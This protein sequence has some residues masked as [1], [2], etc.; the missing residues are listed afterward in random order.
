[1]IAAEAA[2]WHAEFPRER[3]ELVEA[4]VAHEMRPHASSP[5]PTRTVHEDRHTAEPTARQPHPEKYWYAPRMMPRIST[6][7]TI[8]L[9][10]A[11]ACVPA[12]P[13]AAKDDP[14]VRIFFV[15]PDAG[16]DAEVAREF[17]FGADVAAKFA[18]PGQAG[19]ALALEPVALP[20]A[21][22][23]TKAALKSWRKEAALVVAWLPHGRTAE[24]EQMAAKAKV[25]LLVVS[26]E[27]TT[28]SLDAKRAVFWAG[29]SPLQDET[30]QALDYALQPLGSSQPAILHDG[31]PRGVA[32]AKAAEFW[33]HVSQTLKPAI[34]VG[35]DW[36][37][38]QAAAL[39]ADGFDSVIYFGAPARAEQ[40]LQ[41]MKKA[42][43]K[44]P[45]LL[46]TGLVS[47]A[48]PTFFKGEAKGA[49]AME[50]SWFEDLGRIG[51][52]DRY[53]LVDAA[54]AA[55]R[56]VLP[57]MMRG[58]R[59]LLW[60]KAALA[61]AG[62]GSAKKFVPAL[63]ALTRKGAAEKTVFQPYGHAS[64]TRFSLWHSEPMEKLPACHERPV[65]R[66]PLAG[67][68][69]VGFFRTQNYG[70][71]PD[72]FHVWVRFTEEEKRT[73]E[74]DLFAIGLNTK[75]YE[76]DL[77]ARLLDD[78]LGR[79]ISKMNRLFLRN[80]DGR[81]IPGVS[82]NISFSPNPPPDGVRGGK[83]WDVLI[84]GDDPVAGGRA[85]GSTAK[86]FST[87]IRRTMYV[88]H[89]LDPPM[90]A[91]D[92][93]H[94][95]GGYE[96]DTS[97]DEN[98]RNGLVRSLVGGFTQAMGLTGAHELGHLAGCGHDTEWGRSIMNVASGAGLDFEW[99]DWIPAHSK[100][101][102]KR[103]GR[104]PAR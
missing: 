88:Q 78:L 87:F 6:V 35:D 60:V 100:V 54:K 37:G 51:K 10:T 81:A 45:V 98:I 76:E 82:Y 72:S 11:I 52:E 46:T 68:P 27:P 74:A 50:P 25:P 22:A 62:D 65:T 20:S 42:D 103:L 101:L 93:K 24:F 47:A 9:A 21:G 28:P 7:L 34:L 39:S 3:V 97:A 18:L 12:T 89:K 29:G 55:D 79:V 8:A 56:T 4:D 90:S 69:A 5:S 102:E 71:D 61:A 32:C 95:A 64:L 15:A 94:M 86:V 77:E 43:S 75:G 17:L 104:V 33:H 84:G 23:K 38:A 16:P 49:W 13:A 66:V 2:P 19:P 57:A 26:P 58:Q 70:W 30:L 48:V 80:P 99:A 44:L 85:S 31:S 83:K 36:G 59:V 96:W 73:I 40:M 53:P 92:R 1:V 14:A 41:A 67:V 91:D 63:R